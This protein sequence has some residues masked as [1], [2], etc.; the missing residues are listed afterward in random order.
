MTNLWI[1]NFRLFSDDLLRLAGLSRLH[2]GVG[3]RKDDHVGDQ[4][5]DAGTEDRDD[6]C[7]DD[8]KLPVLFVIEVYSAVSAKVSNFEQKR[9]Q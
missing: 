5:D 2:L 6:D 7:K 4:D 3:G 9:N 1:F 8:V